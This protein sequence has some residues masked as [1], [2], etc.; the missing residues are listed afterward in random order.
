MIEKGKMGEKK[1]AFELTDP[2]NPQNTLK[3]YIYKNR[4]RFG[5]M[6]ITHVNGSLCGQ[7]IFG[8]PKVLHLSKNINHIKY[9][10]CKIYNKIDGTNILLF[11]YKDIKGNRFISFK[12]RLSPFLRPQ[13][14]GDFV[15]LWKTMLTKYENEFSVLFD[16]HFNFGFEL[17]GSDLRILTD[18][19]ENL[20][21][22]LIFA[23]D[24]EN[25]AIIDSEY[26]EEWTFPKA[27]RLDEFS[28]EVNLSHKYKEVL[29]KYQNDFN[30]GENVEGAMFY[31]FS[32]SKTSVYKCKPPAIVSR[33]ERYGELYIEGKK[34]SKSFD[35]IDEI[36]EGIQSYI[37]KKWDLGL[38]DKYCR[39]IEIVKED[40]TNEVTFNKKNKS[41]EVLDEMNGILDQMVLWKT[42]WG[43]H[44]WGMDKP[45][46]D[47]D[48]CVVY[49]IDSE[50]VFLSTFDHSILKGHQR[51]TRSK[52]SGDDEHWY[53]LGRAIKLILKGSVS[54]LYGIMSPIIEESYSTALQELQ[55]IIKSQ[56]CK[57]FYNVILRYSRD[58]EK[59]MGRTIDRDFYLKHLRIACRD[60]QFGITLLEHNRYEFVPS[61]TEDP[62]DM[63]ILRMKLIEVYENSDLP[64]TFD[65]KPFEDYI[66]RWRKHRYDLDY[67]Q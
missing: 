14:Y 34:L 11:R 9:Q 32:D 51:G 3:G 20:D 58:S 48:C 49:Q 53:E 25:G 24:P 13:P 45:G 16:S 44:I 17:F 1:K 54:M 35:N 47:R 39:T 12:T 29:N 38:R 61:Y 8:M 43:S 64:E 57:I 5:D 6:K 7:Y 4:G 66:V 28:A 55:E 10:T 62:Q 30:A 31:F 19:P 36:M 65:Q 59:A 18:Y 67:S 56:P 2:F 46:S 50:T 33:Q 60:L 42:I 23:L 37:F 63:E 52:A 21:V 27:K 41:K 15:D 26:D 22:R 40:I